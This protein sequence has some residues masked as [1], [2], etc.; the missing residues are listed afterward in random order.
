MVVKRDGF[1]SSNIYCGVDKNV[2]LTLSLLLVEFLKPFHE[3]TTHCRYILCH[4]YINNKL[5]TR[6]ISK[7]SSSPFHSFTDNMTIMNHVADGGSDNILCCHFNDGMNVPFFVFVAFVLIR[8][9]L[10]RIPVSVIKKK[11]C[12]GIQHYGTHCTVRFKSL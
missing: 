10:L 3:E 8:V 9:G 1:I 2:L 7:P 6:K 4:L 5:P 12:C 11:G